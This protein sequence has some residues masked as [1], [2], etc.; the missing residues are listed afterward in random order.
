MRF[1][2]KNFPHSTTSSNQSGYIAL[3]ALLIVAAAALTIGITVSLSGLDELQVSFGHSQAQ[4][5]KALAQTCVEAG[6]EQLR[7]NFVNYSTSLSF[8]A[9]SCIINIVVSGGTASFEARGSV[10]IYQQRIQGQLANNLEV[11]S[12]QEE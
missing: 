6:L 10:D 8:G 5:A 12:W 9:G 3:I 7:Q 2:S 11:I 4:T 1:F